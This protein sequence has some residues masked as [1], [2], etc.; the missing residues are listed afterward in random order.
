MKH[1]NTTPNSV[2]PCLSGFRA[3][4]PML[5]ALLLLGTSSPLLAQSEDCC[6]LGEK[7]KVLTLKYTGEDC[8]ATTHNQDPSKVSCTGDPAFAP[9]VQ[10]I[11]NTKNNPNDGNIWFTGTVALGHTFD[12]DAANANKDKLGANTWVHVFD[13]NW[14]LLQRVQFHTSCSQPITIGNQFGSQL[15]MEIT[16]TND[17]VCSGSP[18]EPECCNVADGGEIGSEEISCGPFDPEIMTGITDPAPGDCGPPPVQ[19]DCCEGAGKVANLTVKYTG[20]D[21]SATV[22]QQDPSKV[23]CSG[24]PNFAPTV[25]IVAN[26]KSNPND[27]KIWFNGVVELNTTFDISAAFGGAGELKSNTYVHIF[28]MNWQPLQTLKFHTSCSQ[29]LSIGNQFGSILIEEVV[30]TDGFVCSTGGSD[31]GGGSGEDCCE[32]AGKVAALTVLYTGEDC[33]AT[34]HQQDPS[35][36]SCFGDPNFAQTVRI[37][38][39]EKSNPND[40][41]IWF[42]GVVELNT[43]FDISAAFG[44]AGELKSNT[45][46]HIFDMNWQPLQILKFHT[47]CSQPLSIG[48]Q[49]GSI[50]IEEVVGTDGFVC[51][52]G[53]NGGGGEGQGTDCCDGSKPQTLT[54]TYNGD[55]CGNSSNSQSSDK[56][57]CD[58]YNGGPSQTASVYII[59]S[60]SADGSGSEIYFSGPVNAGDTFTASATNAGL[61]KF[62]SNTYFNIFSLANGT[63]LQRV[64]IH[65]SCSVSLAVG[66]QFGS[67]VVGNVV[68]E[69]G[70]N[71][72]PPPPPPGSDLEYQWLSSTEGCPATLDDA[73][74]GATGES[75]DP[76]HITKTTWYVRLVRSAGCAGENAGNEGWQASNCVMKRVVNMEAD[77]SG[78]VCNDEGTATPDNDTWSFTL[79][80]SGSGA[81]WTADIS[82]DAWSWTK[83]GA[84]GTP[85]PE[86]PLFIKHGPVVLDISDNDAP[87][88]HLS[89]VIL[90]PPPCSQGEPKASLGD[91]VWNDLDQ[92]GK[93]DPN[94]PGVPG[95]KVKLFKCDGSYVAETTTN[96]SGLYHFPDLEPN[97]SY[98]VAFSGI[99]AGFEFT[100]P[101]VGI[102]ALD[103]D[104]NPADGTTACYFLAS[105]ENETRVD[106]GVF[107]TPP[108]DIQIHIEN[109]ACNANDPL[110]P[111]DD[112]W[113]FDIVV[114]GS[115]TS[116]MWTGSYDNAF[117][118]AYFIPATPYGTPVH[119]S[120]VPVAFDINVY[121]N[122]SV[123]LDCKDY[124]FAE[125]P[126]LCPVEPKG[127]IGDYV[128]FDEN[129][130]GIQDEGE[131]GMGD[132]FVF[133]EDCNGNTLDFT[134]TDATG[135]YMFGGLDAGEYAVQFANP[136][137]EY[138]GFPLMITTPNAGINDEKDS[139]ADQFF[140]KSPCITLAPGET[141]LSIDA[142]FK[143]SPPPPC[144]NVT[145]GGLIGYDESNCGSYDPE[146]IVNIE[147]PTGGSGSIEYLWLASTAGCPDNMSQVIPGI[148]SPG[149]DPPTI[150]QTTW[151]IRCSRRVGC[152]QWI[153]S[154]CIVKEVQPG[155]EECNITLNTS[156][157]TLTIGGLD[158]PNIIVQVFDSL[159]NNVFT[160]FNNCSNPVVITGLFPSSYFVKVDMAD[161]EWNY[162]CNVAEWVSVS[163]TNLMAPP[164]SDVTNAEK[165]DAFRM[166]NTAPVISERNGGKEQLTASSATGF[167]MYPNPASGSVTLDWR[168]AELGERVVVNLYNSLGQLV[169]TRTLDDAASGEYKMELGDLR[170]GQYIVQFRLDGRPP[171]M[172][173]L[174]VSQ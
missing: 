73:I 54:L 21:C 47:S 29:P 110:T 161:G 52:T 98:F 117:Y 160:C 169:K 17:V 88:C 109:V 115:N 155:C 113:S 81:G 126:G 93:Q 14:N 124:K 123:H 142:G 162:Y 57:S 120:G 174:V 107:E 79:L 116:G 97:M 133:L 19:E 30:G 86:G 71:C 129:G 141:N 167:S 7:I 44:G 139:D 112:T 134:L 63:L 61:T 118:G 60:K 147:L 165:P 58:D 91:F 25:R 40:G 172:K 111:G 53:G 6:A 163:G 22:H 18:P 32:G 90:P 20:E 106:A 74:A 76:E 168:G 103:S 65:T 137:E 59:A 100:Q 119:V 157:H 145:N 152:T 170:A 8:T 95:V 27:G 3:L 70:T 158:G 42:N 102:E 16:L 151:Y 122:D 135:M 2:K 127:K 68:F 140:G 75:Y 89:Q 49:F 136:G 10:I 104:A 67:L 37:V 36:V 13:M 24:D 12:L 164:P 121:A 34:V 92:D 149:Y 153:E 38:A 62:P 64:K 50:L 5:A 125:S 87:Q 46:V 130:N 144:D 108:C 94:E 66:D 82:N 33:S 171:V 84:Y 173:K 31:G 4:L 83:S 148:N 26:E 45:Y 39:N 96:G 48:N 105:G 15:V 80:V 1:Y 77:V 99:P 156:P 55:N 51:S 35:K 101:N 166:G 131:P 72:G 146:P 132:V 138:F 128:W 11:A 9:S 41:K 154:N 114:S 143:A 23:S 78:I 85:G 69:D 150:N 43:T 56:W 28:D 159:W